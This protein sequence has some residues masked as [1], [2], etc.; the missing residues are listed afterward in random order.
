M[1]PLSHIETAATAE[2]SVAGDSPARRCAVSC[3][4][5]TNHPKLGPKTVTAP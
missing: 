1:L 5:I 4:C 2:A 3:C